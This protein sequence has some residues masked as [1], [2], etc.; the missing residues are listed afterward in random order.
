VKERLPTRRSFPRPGVFFSGRSSFTRGQAALVLT[1]CWWSVFLA[2]AAPAVMPVP[3]GGMNFVYPPVFA[4]VLSNDPSAAQPVSVGAAAAGGNEVDIRVDLPEMS[5]RV[6]VY[7]GLY[8][9]AVHPDLLILTEANVFAPCSEAGL[10]PWRRDTI[11]PLEGSLFGSIPF[12]FLPSGTYFLCLAVTPAG[13]FDGHFLWITS[14]QTPSV[15]DNSGRFYVTLSVQPQ[16]ILDISQSGADVVFTLQGDRSVFEG[17]GTIR[18]GTMTLTAELPDMS[19][20][21]NIL[22]N[23]SE[24]GQSFA[25]RWGMVPGEHEGTITGTRKI[26]PTYDIDSMGIPRFASADVID[27]SK[28]SWISRFRSGQGHDYSDDFESC[29]S[30]KHYFVPGNQDERTL[31]NIFAPCDGTVIATTE[32]WS[33]EIGWKG[34]NVGI[35]SDEYPAFHFVVM[36]IELIKALNVG[37]KIVAGQLLGTPPD[38]ENFTM[39]DTAVGVNTPGGYRLISYFD[40]M[41]DTVFSS[42]QAR[43]LQSRSDAIISREERD[44][45]P[46]T[47]VGEEQFAFMGNIENWVRLDD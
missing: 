39:A 24:D 17:E 41:T 38:Y 18:G 16:W 5:G 25:G 14:F 6:D 31:V 46:L 15:S 29:R 21:L 1:V 27:L 28:V 11:G 13:T 45:D 9:P 8:A 30:M 23:F 2:G 35:Q 22:A 42:Y 4:P 32:E 36:H 20:S 37:E 7:F 40:V 3:E 43:G 34:T 33:E 10:E 44:A 47:C 26:W 12:S 19:G